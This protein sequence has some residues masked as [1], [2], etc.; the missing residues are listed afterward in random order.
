MSG[1]AEQD[2][3]SGL[4]A[5]LEYQAAGGSW[6]SVRKGAAATA[7]RHVAEFLV[8]LIAFTAL[9]AIVFWQ[10]LPHL[11][12]ALLGPPEDNL[13]DFWNSWYA[14]Q[15][16]HGAFFFTRL[17][18]APEGVS[19]YYHSFA[20]PQLVAIWG[21]SKIFGA[22]LPVLVLLQNL[23]ILAT[24]PL[25][26]VG[27]FYLCRH[28]SGSA[29]GAAAGGFIFA[30][31]PWHIA[32]AMHHAHVAGIEFLPFFV[33]C[34]LLAM[35]R[36][37]YGWLG[38]AIIFYALSALSC[39]YYLFYCLYFLAFH[40]LYL[41]VHEHR[42]PRGWRLAAP[43][44]CLGGTMLLL[45]PLIVPMAI[46]GLHASAYQP[47]SN[48]VV[49]DLLG[50]TAFPPTHLLG[51]WSAGLY[52]AFSGNAW[53]ATVYLGLANIAVLV[54]GLWQARSE[55]RRVIW[56]AIGGTIFFVVLA[57]GEALHWQ[58]HTLP[59]HMPDIILSKLPFFANV[60]TPARAIVFATLFLGVGV[61][62]A[63]AAALEIWRGTA[64]TTAVS[65]VAALI[66]LDFYP[67]HLTVTPMGCAPELSVI[68]GDR[69]KDFS[70]L[71]M[72]FGY[73]EMNFYMAQ[74][75]C[76]RRPIVQ[77]MI[78]RVLQHTLA[79]QLMV[80]DFAAQQHQL[81]AAGVKYILLHHPRGDL[82]HWDP[83]Y[84]GDPDQYRRTYQLMTDGPDM[85]VLRVY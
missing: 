80:K 64:A 24:F 55:R 9:T 68:A 79:N 10:V 66:L 25:A 41:R 70:V 30:F 35:E 47:G 21:L 83:P 13:Q 26:G 32:Q 29:A 57:S 4:R 31:S 75:I 5:P 39:W 34:Y 61:A 36:K 33:L 23:T 37:N 81:E 63:A 15:G 84:D 17:I 44:L 51:A 40:L 45:S 11:S 14:A 1:A 72:P 43:A 18:R 65:A 49:A 12:S 56:Y 60:R 7:L 78:A 74:Q 59:I 77:G 52:H 82:F 50:Y 38:G 69:D 67:A 6:S 2:I 48:I 73:R 16:H 53:E 19:L 85:T 20:Y 46:S 22:S 71:D 28:L 54:W 58:G 42:W 76:H 62:A 27:G 3:S 8:L